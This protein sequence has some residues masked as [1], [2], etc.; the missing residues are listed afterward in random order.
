MNENI[1]FVEDHLELIDELVAIIVNKHPDWNLQ[2]AT[3]ISSAVSMG[4]MATV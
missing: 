1:L 2:F 4:I 3:D